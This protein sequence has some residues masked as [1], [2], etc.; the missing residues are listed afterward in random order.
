V[1][2][3]IA[4]LVATTEFGS[5]AMAQQAPPPSWHGT[6]EWKH[7]CLGGG[8]ADETRGIG[9]L[10][11]YYSASGS[12][13]GLAGHRSDWTL[14]GRLTGTISER[15]QTIPPCSFTY[16]A[17]GT[18]SASVHGSYTPA[19]NTFSASAYGV[20]STPGRASF[21]CPQAPAIEV[22]QAYFTVYEGPMFEDAFRELRREPGGGWKSKGERTVSVGGGTCTTTYA[23]TLHGCGENM[24][25]RGTIY[26]GPGQPPKLYSAPST[27][28]PVLGSLPGGARVRYTQ[29]RQVN[30]Q[31]WYFVER[32]TNQ[33][34][35]GRASDFSC[36]LPTRPPAKKIILPPEEMGKYEGR[37]ALASAGRG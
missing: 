30:G 26:A 14:N 1:A 13:D 34:G 33:K 25:E 23:L 9:T 21:A 7:L 12:P 6:F 17:P 2:V 19:Q 4:A 20:N 36:G 10:E 29:T 11:L 16:V 15:S 31:T 28:S 24:P 5:D 18:F 32:A 3:A 37:A 27:D 8:N 22:D 35:W